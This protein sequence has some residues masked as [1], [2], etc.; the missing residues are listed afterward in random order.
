MRVCV[1]GA[2][3]SGTEAARAASKHN[4]VT[5]IECSKSIPVPR[6]VWPDAL[7]STVQYK[8]NYDGEVL[9]GKRV[10]SVSKDCKVVVGDTAKRFD[11]V[12]LCSGAEQRFPRFNERKEGIVYLEDIS[13]YTR[14]GELSK[15]N[16]YV[17]LVGSGILLLETVSRMVENKI[18]VRIFT[19]GSLT[20]GIIAKEV[21]KRL[22]DILSENKVEVVLSSPERIVGETSVEGI[23]SG[24]RIYPSRVVGVFPQR[25]PPLNL[26]SG[27]RDYI[28]VDG[29]LRCSEKI[30]AA[31]SCS[32]FRVGNTYL[33]FQTFSASR[34]MGYVAGVN[35]SGYMTYFNPSN[36]FTFSIG[37]EIFFAS[38]I[39]FE[40][41]L[42]AGYDAEKYTHTCPHGSFQ[43]VY[44]KSMKF[45][46]LSCA[47]KGADKRALF[48]LS[49]SIG[50]N[51]TSLLGS[52]MAQY[53]LCDDTSVSDFIR[54][55]L[56]I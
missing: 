1:V 36:I 29:L 40:D 34:A 52:E 32:S 33:N 18:R 3:V 14:L 53:S 23:I 9:T 49:S 35:C 4:E 11:S 37:N 16:G 38:G 5:L 25:Y 12:I 27:S 6:N 8:L 28:K 7:F 10:T 41:A 48:F 20:E 24:G 56:K 39:N 51:M 31:G 19:R 13:S 55:V 30:Y 43:I 47:G 46:G 21:E 42:S 50:M 44:D 45:L 22:F 26:L 15:E 54:E 2:G 17:S